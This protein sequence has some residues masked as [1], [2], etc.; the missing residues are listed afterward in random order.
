VVVGGA[1][2]PSEV[3][4]YAQ[5]NVA[6]GNQPHSE[7]AA[8]ALFMEGWFGQGGSERHFPDAKLIIEPSARGKSVVDLDRENKSD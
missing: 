8:L 3:F 6:V 7:V 4:E 5:Y 2:V 1:K